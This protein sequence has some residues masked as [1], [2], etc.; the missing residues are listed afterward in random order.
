[1]GKKDV[2]IKKENLCVCEIKIIKR[3]MRSCFS[4]VIAIEASKTLVGVM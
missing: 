3:Q 2:K 1:M 4:S